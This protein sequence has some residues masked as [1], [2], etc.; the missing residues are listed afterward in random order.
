MN[1]SFMTFLGTFVICAT[2]GIVT[3][4]TGK[5]ILS[6]VFYTF[7]AI[8]ATTAIL[9]LVNPNF[10]KTL[11]KYA[12]AWLCSALGFGIL[13]FYLK[14]LGAE[15]STM[16][17][18][19]ATFSTVSI[20]SAIGHGFYPNS[21]R[22]SSL[23]TIAFN[24]AFYI[25]ITWLVL[26]GSSAPLE[27][28]KAPIGDQIVNL[29]PQEVGVINAL[30]IILKS[31]FT[32]QPVQINGVLPFAH[33]FLLIHIGWNFFKVMRSYSWWFIGSSITLPF[34]IVAW[35]NHVPRTLCLITYLV[36]AMTFLTITA[37]SISLWKHW[38]NPAT[39]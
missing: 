27:M 19:F 7:A 11:N 28:F 33:F 2:I 32:L 9:L 5:A 24:L 17:L 10:L 1:K 16:T 34:L 14:T 39:S 6:T 21:E 20:I 30:I 18:I 3:H 15:Y 31:T 4:A 13:A 8:S 12:V 22:A 25:P 29:I 26:G 37:F 23:L 36:G 35:V 38:G